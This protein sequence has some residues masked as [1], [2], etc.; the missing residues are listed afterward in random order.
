M[1]F[2]VAELTQVLGKV[3]SV[4]LP[5]QQA[6]QLRHSLGLAE[7][8]GQGNL[9]Q[10]VAEWRKQCRNPTSTDLVRALMITPG[11]GRY[12]SGLVPYCELVP[13]PS[14]EAIE[15]CTCIFCV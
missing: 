2:C 5:E 6:C 13:F 7:S 9:Q 3:P 15:V 1:Y 10:I 12:V 8:V 4:A 11:L 14:V